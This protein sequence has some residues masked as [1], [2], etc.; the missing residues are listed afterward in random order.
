MTG[1]ITRVVGCDEPH[2]LVSGMS[3][4]LPAATVLIVDDDQAGAAV[5]A[6]ALTSAGYHVHIAYSA[7]DALCALDAQRP[8]VIVLDFRMP[9]INGIG[10]LYRLRARPAY[11]HT[12]VLLVT[13]E[14]FS[15]RHR[16]P[17]SGC[18]SRFDA[19]SRICA[20]SGSAP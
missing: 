13:G 8:D 14:P 9:L 18:D 15:C 2:P 12:P 3:G 20:L 10:F 4:V 5:F 19:R 11:R 17:A 6:Y 16:S 7:E 1:K